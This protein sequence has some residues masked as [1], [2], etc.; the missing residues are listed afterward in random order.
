VSG[1]FWRGSTIAAVL[2]LACSPSSPPAIEHEDAGDIVDVGAGPDAKIRIEDD[3][4]APPRAP[5]VSGLLP[6]DFPP[7]VPVYTPSSLYDFGSEAA[8]T[9]YIT[10]KT[11]DSLAKVK[12][13]LEAD[14]RAR[15]WT[16]ARQTEGF[17]ATKGARRA[18]VSWRFEAGE[19]FVTIG[20]PP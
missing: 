20:Y 8:G 6:E 1:P 4:K 12:S 17:S 14:F 9:P 15:G 11:G 7:D 19:S 5:T 13:R 10:L 16:L 18:T 3:V 2:A